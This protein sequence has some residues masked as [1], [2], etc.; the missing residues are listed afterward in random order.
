M[1]SPSFSRVL[2]FLGGLAFAG[3][4]P[5]AGAQT[6][7]FDNLG[8]LNGQGFTSYSESGYDVDLFSGYICHAHNFGNPTPDLFGGQVCNSGNRTATVR[9]RRSGGGLFS[10]IATD[11]SSQNGT[12]SYV[13]QGYLA[14]ASQYSNAGTFGSGFATYANANATTTIDELHVALSSQGT[15]FNIDNIQV[16]G[17][18][19]TPEPAS[20]VLLGTGLIGVFAVARR[21][22]TT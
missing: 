22:R 10:Y 17:V 15:S 8:G 14:A 1:L 11:L 18:V 4:A 16:Q 20:M 21:K 2:R 6:V 13:F 19:A 5:I 9:V 7:T 3:L 12:G